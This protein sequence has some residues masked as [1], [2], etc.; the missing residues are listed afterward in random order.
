MI[1]QN[2][3]QLTTSRK[4][5]ANK[6]A[7]FV[8]D[9]IL[10][11]TYDNTSLIERIKYRFLNKLFNFF[12]KN[13][14]LITSD[15]GGFIFTLPFSHK[16]PFILKDNPYY[17]SNLARIA[18]HVKEK[19]ADLKLIDV[20]ANIGDSV[21]ILRKEE[22]FPILCIEG[23]DQFY[24]ILEINASSFTELYI[25]KEFLGQE[26]KQMYFVST[27]LGGTGNLQEDQSSTQI[28]E[29]KKLSDLIKQ[30]SVFENAKMLKIDTDGFD[31]K[32]IRGALSFLNQAKPVIF[33][34]YDPFFLNKQE[35]D[36]FSIFATLGNIGY[37]KILIYD[38]FGRLL[39]T[40][41]IDNLD[42]M[43]E[44]H[45]YFLGRKSYL[46]CDICVFH[47]ED[48]DLFEVTR[49]SEIKFFTNELSNN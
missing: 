42:L 33:F 24:S 36:G 38:N 1:A 25:A 46:Y 8:Y 37:K 28:V 11:K 35:D 31:C 14:P 48:S 16:L 5:S 26:T 39:I 9:Q 4:F 18:K 30:Y 13:D 43:K 40:S 10:L 21:A 15:I 6:F 17:S 22:F 20:G 47:S 3:A 34:E 27:K 23:D 41:N 29:I 12:R 45:L 49:E 32:I 19:Y 7:Q 44:I 2:D